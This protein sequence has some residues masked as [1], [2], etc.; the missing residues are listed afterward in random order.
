MA[1][2]PKLSK[3]DVAY[4]KRLKRTAAKAPKRPSKNPRWENENWD[5]VKIYS[6]EEAKELLKTPRRNAY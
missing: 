3:S 5:G 2:E 1:D 4:N 6:A